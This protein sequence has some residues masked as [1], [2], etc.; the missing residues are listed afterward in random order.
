MKHYKTSKLL[1]NST[2]SKFVTRKWVEVN[3]LSSGQYSASKSIR[4]KTSMLRS[5]L[6][7]QSDAYIVVKGKI[8]VRGTNNANIKNKKLTIKNNAPFRS[9]ISKINN[10]FIDNAEDLDIVMPMYNLLE[11]S[12]N[13]SKASASFWNY[14]R[15]KINNYANKNNDAINYRINNNKTT[16]SKSFE[17]KVKIIG[18]TPNDNNILK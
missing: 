6:C 5:N 10:A 17:Y 18:R 16:T 2:V 13:Y 1:T 3:D 8:S 15:D 9:Y 4:F 11:Y 7:D 12:G 14:Y